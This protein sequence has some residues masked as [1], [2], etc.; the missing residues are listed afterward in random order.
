MTDTAGTSRHVVMAV[1]LASPPG[2]RDWSFRQEEDYAQPPRSL[3]AWGLEL[4]RVGDG[5]GP[6]AGSGHD[7]VAADLRSRS[8]RRLKQLAGLGRAGL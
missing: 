5:A 2:L 7:H 4:G 8:V 6:A 3:R 1:G